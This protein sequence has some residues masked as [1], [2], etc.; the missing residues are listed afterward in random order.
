[1]LDQD[2]LPQDDMNQAEI[3]TKWMAICKEPGYVTCEEL[4]QSICEWAA[5]KNLLQKKGD[6]PSSKPF[7]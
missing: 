5:E 7:K 1:V 2:E 3:I 4:Q 6:F